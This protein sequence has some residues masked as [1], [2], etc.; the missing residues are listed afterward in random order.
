MFTTELT[1]EELK[2]NIGEAWEFILPQV[3]DPDLDE[4]VVEIINSDELPFVQIEQSDPP[5]LF[6]DEG[7]TDADNIE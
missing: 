6:I 1:T 7:A 3:E 5:R 4:F 2:F